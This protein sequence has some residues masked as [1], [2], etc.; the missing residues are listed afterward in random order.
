MEKNVVEEVSQFV[1]PEERVQLVRLCAV[2]VG[3]REVAEDLAQETLLEAWR[4]RHALR[5]QTRRTSWLSGIARNVCLRWLRERRRDTAHLIRP[6]VDP[7]FIAGYSLGAQLADL[8]DALAD[9]LDIEVELERKELVE[10][11]D[12]ALA[13][14]PAETRVVLVKRYVEESPLAE[15]AAQ[16]GT[17]AHAVAVR[18][19]RGRLALRHVLTTHAS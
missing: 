7:R 15:V 6:S 5:D 16:L 14:L 17:N 13:L 9:D 1:S 2:L 19:Q 11:L 18:L 4:H 10:L 8:E 12:R 3:D